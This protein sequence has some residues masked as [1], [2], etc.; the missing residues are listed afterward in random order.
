[1]PKAA[2]ICIKWPTITLW[3]VFSENQNLR[4]PIS[5]LRKLISML[6]ASCGF[7]AQVHDAALSWERETSRMSPEGE[8]RGRCA[9]LEVAFPKHCTAAV[10]GF[11]THH[12]VTGGNW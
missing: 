2:Q 4:H 5:Y 1:M 10:G 3:Y 8:S 9:A 7:E 12:I 6:L 11:Q